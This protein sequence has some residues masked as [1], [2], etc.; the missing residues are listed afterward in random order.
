MWS[1][2][3]IGTDRNVRL[4]EVNVLKH[5]EDEGILFVLFKHLPDDVLHL[6]RV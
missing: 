1:A 2:S 3:E 6:A 4:L 5:R